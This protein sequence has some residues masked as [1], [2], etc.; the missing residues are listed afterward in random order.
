MRSI[1][2]I[3]NQCGS[4]IIT[5]PLII[6][7]GMMII[8]MIIVIAVN[9]I[10]PYLWYEKLSSASIKY[11]YVMEEFGYLTKNE[12]TNLKNELIKQGFE[13]EKM[14]IGYTSTRV[15]YGNPIFLKIAYD[16]KIDMPFGEDIDVPMVITRNSV[17]KR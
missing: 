15:S 10:T 7:I 16:Y 1:S 2:K 12:I 4:A 6:A 14:D 13:E 11:I 3:K 9:V 8:S 17:S 5:T